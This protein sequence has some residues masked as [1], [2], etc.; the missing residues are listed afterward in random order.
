MP[1][2]FA[3]QMQYCEFVFHLLWG[4]FRYRISSF[5]MYQRNGGFDDH[6]KILTIVCSYNSIARLTGF[7]EFRVCGASLFGAVWD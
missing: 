1:E 2:G 6:Q 7:R 3:T 5:K 4:T